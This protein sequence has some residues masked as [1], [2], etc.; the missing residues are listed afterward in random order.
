MLRKIPFYG[1]T[2]LHPKRSPGMTLVSHIQ[3]TA[4]DRSIAVAAGDSFTQF[5]FRAA[6]RTGGTSGSRL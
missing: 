5:E 4:R 1:M 6:G 2:A 3:R